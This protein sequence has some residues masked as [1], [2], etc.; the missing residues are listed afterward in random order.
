MK[1][2]DSVYLMHLFWQSIHHFYSWSF[3]YTRDNY[4]RNVDSFRRN[5]FM[6]ESNAR[7]KNMKKNWNNR[8]YVDRIFSFFSW[9]DWNFVFFTA[10]ENNILGKM[11][12]EILL[13]FSSW[14]GQFY[15]H[16]ICV[17]KSVKF[18]KHYWQNIIVEKKKIGFCNFLLFLILLDHLI[19]FD[20]I[21][22]FFSRG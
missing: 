7:I 18:Q 22:I 15:F 19:D 12:W 14:A 9:F 21:R 11:M 5:D 1:I 16:F 6:Y 4:V 20:L 8:D 3:F 2:F 10:I 13:F 17:M